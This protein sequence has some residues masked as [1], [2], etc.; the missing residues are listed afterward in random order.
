MCLVTSSEINKA[1]LT[2]K[3]KIKLDNKLQALGHTFPRPLLKFN[4]SVW[5]GLGGGVGQSPALR[6]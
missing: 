1:S 5:K 6:G 4:T 3:T 2:M